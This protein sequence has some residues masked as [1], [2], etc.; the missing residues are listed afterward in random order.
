MIYIASPYTHDNPA[1]VQERYE[2]VMEYTA[3]LIKQG[4]VGVSPIVHCH[5]LA[6]KF[7]LPTDFFFWNKYCLSL[8]QSADEMHILMLDG[9]KESLGIQYEKSFAIKYDIPITE[10][11]HATTA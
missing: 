4:D 6:N 7:N 5:V 9:W 1:I 10:I 8:L 2:Q 3:E 11:T